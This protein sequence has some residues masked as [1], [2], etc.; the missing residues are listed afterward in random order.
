M[1]L[2]NGSSQERREA[3]IFLAFGHGCWGPPVWSWLG[4][5]FHAPLLRLQTACPAQVESMGCNIPPAPT[6]NENTMC[7]EPVLGML[8]VHWFGRSGM[9][10]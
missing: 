7:I 5:G 1:K 2:P 6:Q 8:C 3:P 10:L 4:N 9:Q